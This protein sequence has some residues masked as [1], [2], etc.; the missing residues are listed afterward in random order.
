MLF[1]SSA[2]E[3]LAFCE[4]QLARYKIPKAVVFVE[5]LPR[6]TLGKVMRAELKERYSG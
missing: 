5:A 4:G 2:E 1:R 3:L 6:N